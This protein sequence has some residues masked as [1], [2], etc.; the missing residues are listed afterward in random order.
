[1]DGTVFFH[2]MLGTIKGDGGQTQVQVPWTFPV[3]HL[4]KC[5]DPRM[6]HSPC[7]LTS[8][9]QTLLIFKNA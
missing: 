9:R 7:T 3:P 5:L 8:L 1:M 6:Y 2:P 4:E